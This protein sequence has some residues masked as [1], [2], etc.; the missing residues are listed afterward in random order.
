MKLFRSLRWKL[1]FAYLFVVLASISALGYYL[2]GWTDRNY[3]ESLKHELAAE[4]RL[5]GDLS[6]RL[7]HG[8]NQE[9]DKLAKNAGEK[10]GR[11]ITII[12]ADGKVLGDSSRD[13]ATMRSHSDRPEVRAALSTGYGWS[14]RLSDTLHSRMLYVT[15]KFGESPDTSGVA[16]ISESLDQIETAIGNIHRVFFIAGLIVFLIAALIGVRISNNITGPIKDMS[17]AARRFAKGDLS[18]KLLINS[19][20]G[21]EI[22]DLAH[23]LNSMA[24][25]LDHM[26]RELGWEKSKL[27]MILDKTDNG[28]IVVDGESRIRMAN[29]AA[30]R[31]L[32]TGIHQIEGL[33]II[34]CTL[35]HDIA[36]LVERVLRTGTSAS[37]E[38]QLLTPP[39]TYLDVYAA[40]IELA[41]SDT[42]AVLV[43]HDI[44]AAKSMDSVRRDFVANVSHELRTPLASIRA[45]AETIA[46]RGRKDPAM[47]ETFSQRIMTEADRLTALSD[48]L[49][50]LAKIEAE[51]RTIGTETFPLSEIVSQ[52]ISQLQ[53]GATHKDIELYSDIADDICVDAD[54]DAVC[55]ILT[56]LVDNAIKYTLQGGKV[57]LSA[58]NE[59][60]H[61]AINVTDTG[62]GIPAADLPR[63]FERF[64]RVDRA[65]S[66]ESGGTGLGLSIV[67]HLVEAHGGKVN[68][69]SIPGTGSTFTFTLPRP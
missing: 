47:A 26:M 15:T 51:R 3:E 66:R 68:V 64:Y 58:S 6:S 56:N 27:Q 29:P 55:Q 38:I 16:R 63:I 13:I 48:D 45:M 67:K 19:E 50:D 17:D 65:R 37:L 41:D 18:R 61:V 23:T 25:E 59:K 40:T 34:E 24:V 28:L 10:L 2:S 46:I 43:M 4:S 53:P 7:M 44:S 12:R 20:P 36:E 52:A 54:R 22:D 5:I 33:S 57:H 9:I 32:G 21:D 14:I 30:V 62:V 60:N 42:G 49:L 69:S 39:Q 1:T 35:S 11:R 8:N 31:F